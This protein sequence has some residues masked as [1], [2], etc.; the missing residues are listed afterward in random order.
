MRTGTVVQ[1]SSA[2]E[3]PHGLLPHFRLVVSKMPLSLSVLMLMA[4][5]LGRTELTQ[6]V[7]MLGFPFYAAV[8]SQNFSK[9]WL[10]AAVLS[11]ILLKGSVEELIITTGAMA[12]YT[13][14]HGFASEKRPLPVQTQ[15]FIGLMASLTSCIVYSLADGLL[16][17]DVMTSLLQGFV[18]FTLIFIFGKALDGYVAFSNGKTLSA[19]EA[20]SLSIMV[21]FAV[22]GL[23]ET[24]VFGFVIRNVSSILV[25]LLFCYRY[26]PGAGAAIGAVAGFINGNFGS[27][28]PYIISAYT[29]C[30]LFA[31]ILRKLGK[32]GTCLGFIMGNTAITIFLNGSTSVLIHLKEIIAASIAYMMIPENYIYR[33]TGFTDLAGIIPREKDGYIKKVREIVVSKLK[34][35][36][37]AFGELSKTFNQISKTVET[38]DK[39][40][41]SFMLDRV[42]DRVCTHCGL[43]SHCWD[44]NFYNTYQALFKI[45]EKLDKKGRITSDDIPQYLM[46]RCERINEFVERI[47]SIYE[48]FKTD[49]MWKTRLSETRTL[50][51]QQIQALSDMVSQLAGEIDFDVEFKEDV[52]ELLYRELARQQI[53]VKNV[54]VYE[55]KHGRLEIT[56]E[57][58]SCTGNKMCKT[59]IEKKVSKITGRKMVKED[60]GCFL[61][62][63]G[64]KCVLKLTEAEPFRVT[65]GVAVAVKHGSSV[66]GDN[67]TFVNSETGK[68]I[69]TISD[70]M[71]SGSKASKQSKATVAMI[72]SF[73][74]AGFDHEV[75]LKLI[76]SMLLLKSNDETFSTIDFARVDLFT[77]EA[78]FVKIGAAPTFIKRENS[79]ESVKSLSLPAGLASSIE[80]EPMRRQ[81]NSG[82]LLIFIT[83]G[84]LDAFGED[85]RE[86]FEKIKEFIMKTD[87]INPQFIADSIIDEAYNRTGKKPED[88]MTVLVSKIWK[89]Y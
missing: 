55:N 78:E 76:N 11:G 87:S 64:L 22:S 17:Y 66:S 24:A 86:A 44:R 71:G 19:E 12:V 70:G 69:I 67:Y 26:G 18:A 80:A 62:E 74:E 30:G 56:I 15:A 77:G 45:V 20:I 51:A 1:K 65:T 27:A 63:T 4:F 57:H 14:V 35:F 5:L 58:N 82:D 13:L 52:E 28:A 48:L 47:N 23:G 42:V 84:V 43:C 50:V 73:T 54:S 7:I 29:F 6:N 89:Q 21:A 41:I 49:V 81:L 3:K 33:L 16:L 38:V 40:D 60:K 53:K 8:V 75:T 61:S 59:A 32:F 46:E 88:D 2:T 37:S 85:F 31:G 10:A 72:E 9:L 36:S 34:G 79:V 68:Y 83:D 25:M 39:K